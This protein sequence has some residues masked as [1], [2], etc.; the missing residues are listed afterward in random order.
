VYDSEKGELRIHGKRFA[1]TDV[2]EF[3][4]RLDLLALSIAV[5]ALIVL[6]EGSFWKPFLVLTSGI[7]LAL[8]SHTVSTWVS[9]LG[10]YYLDQLSALLLSFGYILAAIGFYMR[11]VQLSKKLL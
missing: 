9:T 1:A 10:P 6:R 2:R 7:V 3:C 8:F 11:M 4:K 5:P